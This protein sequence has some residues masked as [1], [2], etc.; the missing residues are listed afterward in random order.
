MGKR[1]LTFI[2]ICMFAVS[3]AFAQK[4]V[5]GSVVESETGEPI[6]GASVLVK[7]TQ[8]GAPTDLN[9]KFTIK[10]VPNS[11]K[12]LVVSYIGMISKEVVI[13]PNLRIALDS[14]TKS[15]NDVLVVAYGTQSKASF[16]GS[17][18]T[19]SAEKLEDLHV[20]NISQALYGAAPGVQVATASGTPG[21]V[22]SIRIRGI[23]SISADQEP[24]IVLDG[25]PYEGSLNSI[26]TQDI[27]SLTILKDASA[28]SMYGSRGANGVIIIT[29]KSGKAGKV[30]IDFDANWGM[31]T[32]GIPNYDIISDPGEYYEMMY[33][34]YRNS[35]I[36]E[37]GWANASL[38][39]ANN[40]ISKNLK[41]NIYKDVADNEI[42]NPYTGKLNP[43]ATQRKWQDD[44]TK[45]PF[46]NGLRQE[47]KVSASTGTETTKA[48][49]SLGYL[50]DEGYMVGSGFERFNGR[51]KID[52]KVGKYINI[53]GSI[54]YTRTGMKTFGDESGNYSNIFMFSQAIAPIYPIYLYN[55]NG[56]LWLDENGNRRY[57]WGTEYT[58]PYA[59]EQN[60]LAAAEANIN[61]SYTDNITSRG[62]FNIKFLK[63]FTFTA[64]IAYDVQSSRQSEFA[65]PI[66]GD[67]ANVNGRGYKYSTRRQNFDDQ[68]ILDWSHDFSGH[69]VSLKFVHENQ[70]KQYEYMYGHMTN[71][72]DPTNDDFANAAQYQGLNSYFYEIAHD[73][74]VAQGNYA[75]ADRYYFNAMIRRDANS[76]FHPDNRWG[77]FWAVGASW[78]LKEEPWLKTVNWVHD[79]KLKASYGTVGNDNIGL[80]H[81]FADLYSVDRID[82]A[83]GLTKTFR[84]NKDLTWEKVGNFN[85]GFEAGFWNRLNVG[86]DF[87]IRTNKDLLY[88]SPLSPSEGKPSGIWRNE[89]DMKNT[90][91]EFEISGDI[92]KKRD[93]V[94][95]ASLN[96][97]HYKNE[98]TRLPA[99]KPAELYPDGYE[100]GSYWRKIGGS[101]YDF[102]SYEYAGVDE[103]TGRALYYVDVDHYY[104]ADGKEISEADAQKL[105]EGK[106]TVETKKDTQFTTNGATRYQT[107]KSA[108]PAL[109]GGFSTSLSWKGLDFAVMTSF[110]IGGW[111]QD[112][113]Y[114]QLMNAGGKGEN[115]HKDMFNRWTPSNTVT[116]IPRL[117]FDGN[118]EGID[119]NSDYYLTNASNFGIRNVTLGYTL[120]SRLT[121]RAGIDKLRIYASGD[122]V[123]LA[124]KR[125]GLNPAI[126]FT[127]ST[128]YV[129]SAIATYSIG[130]NVS[131]GN[132][133]SEVKTQVVPQYIEKEVVKE[134]PVVKEVVKEV[135]GKS[136]LVQNTY[137]VTFPVNS[138]EIINKAEVDGI[139]KGS[140]V[141]IVAYA[142][143]EGNADANM[144]LS[145]K[146][147]DAVADY[148]KSRG[149]NVVRISAKGADTEH[150]NR[151]AIITVK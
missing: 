57:D 137:I 93:L 102:Y 76:V 24:L 59:G 133:K 148:L 120:P 94:W 2:A 44:W 113:Q 37:M 130:I 82:G 68:Q 114:M 111:V 20:A 115:F 103:A 53:G 151:I 21:S 123:W 106:Y 18:S 28:N 134:V 110:Q 122:N 92:I 119:G 43:N 22:G 126:S 138:S 109:T 9:G 144:V 100:S 11:A 83:I 129:Y 87:F 95:N 132:I 50:G 104:D 79:L 13:K 47:Y 72:A 61:K 143:P 112:S 26:P 64:S 30:S 32:R 38:Y 8:I 136:E 150:A 66:G 146:R 33:E 131:L 42:I 17:A 149:V 52:Q 140:T 45:D 147:A 75:Y 80:R 67:A 97:T 27:E 121:K 91:F 16:T 107:G 125:K 70:K 35:L 65:T 23:G 74:Y 88:F 89:M 5:T 12:T 58:R 46:H 54:G 128:G 101:L 15:I 141:E 19:I 48:Y 60:P 41:Y 29:T 116:D 90:G 51:M 10:N 71:F 77:T 55:E 84:G 1:L 139:A 81:A 98:L 63:D 69:N 14:E 145:Q 78:R 36:D 39:A 3:M 31:N 7:G 105:G 96:F 34:S 124:S 142:S 127:G 62:Y 49:F 73:A 25:V 85:V 86:F 108:I 40:L 4:T 135:P 99:S 6:I 56:S 118:S 117:F